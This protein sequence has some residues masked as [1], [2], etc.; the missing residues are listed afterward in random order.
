L[1]TSP[2]ERATEEALVTEDGVRRNVDAVIYGTGFESTSFLAP[3]KIVGRQGLDLND[4]WRSGAEAYLGVAVAGF[5]NLFLLYGPNTNLGH[6]SILFMIECQVRYTIQCIERLR[7]NR[8]ASLEL[9]PD[10]T[11]NYNRQ[12]QDRH[13]QLV[14]S[15]CTNWYT[16]VSGK[17]TKNWPGS[18]V[19]YWLRTRRPEAAAFH[20]QPQ[21]G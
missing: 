13:A 18:T 17:N 14:W 7:K 16:H 12:L 2:I 15:A 20:A 1:V 4:A 9:R 8:L 19:E 6:N 5:P 10:A 3:M 21:V 11:G